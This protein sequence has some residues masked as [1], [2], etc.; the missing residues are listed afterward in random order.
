M[1]TA[2]LVV[3]VL[4]AVCSLPRARTALHVASC[5]PQRV[6][7]IFLLLEFAHGM[8]TR[9]RP[10]RPDQLDRRGEGGHRTIVLH[11]RRL[12][13]NCGHR[14]FPFLSISFSYALFISHTAHVLHT[15]NVLNAGPNYLQIRII[16]NSSQE[17]DSY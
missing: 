10:V 13:T 5:S 16:I 7:A 3:D 11:A 1:F 8:D 17:V 15:R 14:Y 9:R 6:F 4:L 2:P 12:R